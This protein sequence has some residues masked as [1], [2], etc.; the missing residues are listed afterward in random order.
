MNFKI[1]IGLAILVLLALL[2]LPGML[3]KVIGLVMSL[4]VWA[5]SGYL[6][7][8]LLRGEGYGLLGNITAGSGRRLRRLGAGDDFWH[9]RSGQAALPGRD[10]CRGVGRCD[11][12]GGGWAVER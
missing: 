8:K 2:I 3:G 12:C 9:D 7:G 4:L 11:C 5:A 6:A 1:G 10:S